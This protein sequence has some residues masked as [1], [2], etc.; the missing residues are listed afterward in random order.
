MSL[1]G[2]RAVAVGLVGTGLSRLADAL[3]ETGFALV[4][5]A[6]DGDSGL[7]LLQS[8]EPDLAAVSA[9]MPGMDGLAFIERVGRLRLSVVPDMLLLVPEGL[10]LPMAHRLPEMG[11]EAI[12][13]PADARALKSALARLAEREH[14][15]PPEKA[16]RLEA[17]LDELGVPRH[18]GRDCLALAVALVWRDRRL[19]RGMNR[20]L[21]PE[22]ARV[23]DISPAQAERAI[24]HVI[25]A[26]WRTGEIER[27][28]R[29]FGDT[30]D[31]RRGKPTCG[32]M[33]AQLAEELRWEGPQ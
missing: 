1:N 10:R 31:A 33:I 25:E 20:N 9:V 15:L 2:G 5:H 24:R 3:A 14:P 21:Y 30:I 18:R 8:L 7:R 6:P 16:G 4:G 22:V 17:L 11:V 32:E 26:A 12:G 29:I 28:H 23:L 19:L 13:A 27:Q